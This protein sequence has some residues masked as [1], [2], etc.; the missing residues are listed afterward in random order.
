MKKQENSW[1]YD[2]DKKVSKWC[3]EK[4]IVWKEFPYNGV[5]RRL[6]D[7][8]YWK[9]ERDSRMKIALSETP[10]VTEGIKLMEIYRILEI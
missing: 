3:N 5:I 6:K 9:K 4:N 7:R 1:S 10:A 8:D 2:R